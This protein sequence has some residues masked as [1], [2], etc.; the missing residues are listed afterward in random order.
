MP[1]KKTKKRLNSARVA[2]TGAGRPPPAWLSDIGDPVVVVLKAAGGGERVA[3]QV[4]G[5]DPGRR[6]LVFSAEG[7]AS[8]LLDR[9]APAPGRGTV[10]VIDVA[11]L[12]PLGPRGGVTLPGP[13][14][15]PGAGGIPSEP[16]EGSIPGEPPPIRPGSPDV[17]Q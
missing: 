7:T 13:G 2:K 6:E 16:D 10:L 3:C 1:T 12:L 5:V 8:G 15:A 11:G 14:P 4:F 9:L 17:T